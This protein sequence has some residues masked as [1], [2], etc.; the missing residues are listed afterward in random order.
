MKRIPFTLAAAVVVLALAGCGSSP[1]D[2]AGLEDGGAG[3][4]NS[5][6]SSPMVSEQSG[7]PQPGHQQSGQDR[8]VGEA[9]NAADALFATMMIPHHEQAVRMSEMMLAKEDLSP[10]IRELAEQ[11]KAAQGP[12]I[13]QMSE[14]LKAW[15]EPVPVGGHGMG[16]DMGGSGQAME[17]M[18]S[19]QQLEA[20]ETARGT[21]AERLFMTQLIGHHEG[22]IGMAQREVEQGSNPVAVSLARDI[23]AAQQ[24]E[25]EKIQQLL[26]SL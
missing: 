23:I 15:G 2:M 10:K 25:I 18:L 14:W 11:I 22:A 19:A 1:D 8:P 13:R 21:E 3:S 16:H 6:S 7:H 20:L 9:H 12:E 24:S 4:S 26:E 5:P 17:G